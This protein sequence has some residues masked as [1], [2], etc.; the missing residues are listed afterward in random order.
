MPR[1]DARLR[2]EDILAGIRKIVDYVGDQSF[3]EFREDRKTVD[4]VIRNLEVIG[5]AAGHI[6]SP[7]ADRYPDVPWADMRDMRNLLIHEY[8]G[9]DV[10]ILWKTIREDLPRLIDPLQEILRDRSRESD[11]S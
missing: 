2:V 8:F 11:G 10:P 6:P 3:D 4:A 1:R 7:F 9:V 5:E